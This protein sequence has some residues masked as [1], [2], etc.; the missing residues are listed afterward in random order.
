M[1]EVITTDALDFWRPDGPGGYHMLHLGLPSAARSMRLKRDGA[2][3]A[4][5]LGILHGSTVISPFTLLSVLDEPDALI[6]MTF[7]RK[8]IPKDTILLE[9]LES[10]PELHLQEIPYNR[11]SLLTT[12]MEEAFPNEMV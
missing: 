9:L 6:D 1:I 12:L 8:I 2:V 5:A 11:E 10:L 7:L 3:V 4:V